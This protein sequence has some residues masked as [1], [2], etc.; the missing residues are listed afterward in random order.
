MREQAYIVINGLLVA[1]QLGL[2]APVSYPRTG[3][4][5]TLTANGQP[6]TGGNLQ[7]QL[8]VDDVVQAQVFELEED[9][10]SQPFT[11]TEPGL[12]IPALSRLDFKVVTP[13]D[14]T[15]LAIWLESETAQAPVADDNWIV[16]T[17]ALL[18]AEID[19]PT[20]RAF[21]ASLL[22][23]GQADP[24]PLILS[25]YVAMFRNLCSRRSRLGQPGTIPAS[26]LPYFI[27]LSK[28]KLFGRTLAASGYYDKFRGEA[29]EADR[30]VRMVAEGNWPIEPP[31]NPMAT[32][33]QPVP[34]IA[35]DSDDLIDL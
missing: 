4:I 19:A 13:A 35:W 8:L 17:A 14:A 10:R 2:F 16:P 22:N 28:R 11:L 33:D 26:L 24:V 31:T 12:S 21:T 27:A 29:E 5:L 15:D 6:P 23:Q 3:K 9:I 20:Y 30:I 25:S 7:G 32:A 1:D 18:Q 34:G